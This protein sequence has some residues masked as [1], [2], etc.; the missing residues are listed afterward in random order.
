MS[1][2][3]ENSINLVKEAADAAK[4]NLKNMPFWQ[5]ILFK[6]GL[7]KNVL[8]PIKSE[9]GITIN[10]VDGLVVD[11]GPNYALAKRMQ[12]WRAIVCGKGYSPF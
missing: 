11:Q 4:A 10:L 8:P 9:A 7:K 2:L 5:Q 1:K 12:H 3:G 6:F